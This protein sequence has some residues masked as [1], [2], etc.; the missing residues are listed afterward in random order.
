M[1]MIFSILI[2]LFSS[3]GQILSMPMRRE[4]FLLVSVLV[5]AIIAMVNLLVD[6]PLLSGSEGLIPN[7]AKMDSIR[8]EFSSTDIVLFFPSLLLWIDYSVVLY[9]G[10]ISA[11]FG[12][13]CVSCKPYVARLACG[14]SYL[15]LLSFSQCEGV[16]F[17]FPWDC[18]LLELLCLSALVPS[19]GWP[20]RFLLFR[21]MFG[22]GKH[23]F[24]GSDFFEDLLYTKSMACWQPLGTNIG[25]QISFLPDAFHVIAI[26]YTFLSEVVCP[27][28]FIVGS[29]YRKVSCW[30]TVLLMLSI[31]LSGH[32]GWFNTLT[33]CLAFSVLM[34][35]PLVQ[36][37]KKS[38]SFKSVGRTSISL[39]YIFLSVV[40][41]IP[42]QW[43]SPGIFYHNS[44]SSESFDIIRVASSWRIL[45][46]YGV[47]PPK[48][49]P[50]IKPIG[51][52]E[53]ETVEG[54]S[55]FLEYHYQVSG[56]SSDAGFRPFS[57]APLRF[58]RFDYIYAFYA[59][60]HVWS[61]GTRLGPVFGSG[62]QYIDAVA[63]VLLEK[64]NFEFF[65]TYWGG[66]KIAK[67]KFHIVG[68]VPDA[69]GAW[70]EESSELGKEWIADMSFDSLRSG[71]T[72][73]LPPSMMALRRKSLLFK[74]VIPIASSEILEEA[75]VREFNTTDAYFVSQRMFDAS[76]ILSDSD[77][78]KSEKDW[79]K[80]VENRYKSIPSKIGLKRTE[81]VSGDGALWNLSHAS[82]YGGF[83]GCLMFLHLIPTQFHSPLCPRIMQW[84]RKNRRHHSAYSKIPVPD[85]IYVLLD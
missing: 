52:F 75:I 78:Y 37:K 3:P 32:Y 58:P 44:F 24:F 10:I 29:K 61:L 85:A 19:E 50:M 56:N 77:I 53:V 41:L 31:Q 64:G 16:L 69:N 83:I 6:F 62:E 76:V 51:R 68:L 2:S 71:V 35:R 59:A 46:S 36:I 48:K 4:P 1:R 23:K 30:L 49:M 67:V 42:S 55:F 63:R 45:H 34:E 79:F 21:V 22:F 11:C 15:V 65:K 38:P 9:F 25:W 7:R 5:H 82:K 81:L 28:T 12:I 14:F 27:F 72:D 18:L 26:F 66:Q 20:F 13:I 43:T 70:R 8:S 40:F 84:N 74:R 57:V 73:S 54:Q 17:W 39:T 47:F 60:S 80:A 33:A